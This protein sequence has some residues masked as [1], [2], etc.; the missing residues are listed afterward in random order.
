MNDEDLYGKVLCSISP[1]EM[2]EVGEILPPRVHT[3]KLYDESVGEISENNEMMLVKTV[4][5]AFQEHLEF[6]ED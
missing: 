5:E 4:I 1:R 6:M 2:I 3:I